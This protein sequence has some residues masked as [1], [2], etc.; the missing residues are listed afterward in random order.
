MELIKDLGIQ[1]YYRR[2]LTFGLFIC[3]HC[4][5]KVERIRVIGLKSNSCGCA[6]YKS[7]ELIELRTSKICSSKNCEH[8]GEHQPV[9]NFYKRKRKTGTVTRESVCKTCRSKK[10]IENSANRRNGIFGP[11]TNPVSGNDAW[12]KF[13]SV[14]RF[15]L[16][17][18]EGFHPNKSLS[19]NF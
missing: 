8:K 16:K 19:C 18:L 13:G 4:K 3:S 9:E 1:K 10:N 11:K 6:Q 15:T 17:D 14:P 7:R 12:K 5:N 2:N